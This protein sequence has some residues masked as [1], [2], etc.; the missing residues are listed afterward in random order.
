MCLSPDACL[1][2]HC[3]AAV[4]YAATVACRK[5]LARSSPEDK[6][7][8]VTRLNGASPGL[9]E[10][11]EEWEAAH[12]GRDWVTEANLLLPGHKAEWLAARAEGLGE[13]VGVTGDGAGQQTKAT[14][15]LH[16]QEHLTTLNKST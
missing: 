11:Q 14:P 5:V 8:L 7:L 1:P 9:P 3:F 16:E 2:V 6:F 13:V 12:V 10:S 4:L 15:P